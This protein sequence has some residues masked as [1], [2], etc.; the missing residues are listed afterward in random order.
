MLIDVADLRTIP[1]E[2]ESII[3]ADFLKLPKEIVNKIKN[4][5]ICY[6]NDV[7]CAIEDY[8]GPF[9]YLSEQFYKRLVFS[10]ESHEL[11]LYHA[12]KM[13]SKSQV[14]EQGLKTNEWEAYSSLLIESLDSIGFDAQGKCEII[15]LVEKE[16]KRK[17]SVASRKAQLCFFSDMGQMDQEGSAGC[18]QFCESIGGE[19]ARWALKDNHPELY[20]PLK[21]KGESFVVKFRMPFTDVVDFDKETILYQFVSHYA[22]KYFFDFKYDIQFTSMTEFDVPK[23]NILELIPYTKE[24][25]Y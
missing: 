7:R 9:S 5:N 3:M 14:L 20:A 24:V 10:M 16:Y 19:I 4:N 15:R 17:Y 12:T 6:K 1:N 21:N 8:Y 2:I 13:L 11:V 23:E 22:A 18:E 25:N